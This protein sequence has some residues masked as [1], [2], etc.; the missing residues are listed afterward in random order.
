MSKEYHRRKTT[1]RTTKKTTRK[2]GA[3]TKKSAAK[4]WAELADVCQQIHHWWY[5]KRNQRS[6][7]SHLSRLEQILSALPE[8]RSAIVRQEAL[9]WL[10]QL[11]GDLN[12]A[13]RY[14]EREIHLTEMLH[15][16]VRQSVDVG[17]YD[18][19]VAAY[20][21]KGR[22]IDSLKERRAIL[23]SLIDKVNARKAKEK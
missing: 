2:I 18:E 20:A 23:R 17:D 16:S 4:L 8:S 6:A 22:D 15:A 3:R 10:H 21:L 5:V 19:S 11:Q 13:I 1:K 9:A 14:R 12:L 7:K